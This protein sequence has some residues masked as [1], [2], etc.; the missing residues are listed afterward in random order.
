M[1]LGRGELMAAMSHVRVP[2]QLLVVP[3][4][5]EISPLLARHRG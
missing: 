3:S 4:D 5:L 1:T 2:R